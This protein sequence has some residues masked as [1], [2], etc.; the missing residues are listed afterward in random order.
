MCSKR[1]K[2]AAITN[3]RVSLIPLVGRIKVFNQFLCSLRLTLTRAMLSVLLLLSRDVIVCQREFAQFTV[4]GLECATHKRTIVNGQ[5]SDAIIS[6]RKRGNCVLEWAED[7]QFGR[8]FNGIQ[9]KNSHKITD[10]C[11]R[12]VCVG[13]F[14]VVVDCWCNSLVPLHLTH[15]WRA[16]C[17]HTYLAACEC[18]L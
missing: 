17:N 14:F 15:G 6:S 4:F 10:Q 5:R 16:H 3:T 1:I 7:V 2:G 8:Q 9:D 18:V 12:C 11:D 13:I